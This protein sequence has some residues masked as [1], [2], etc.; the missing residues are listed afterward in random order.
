MTG[1]EIPKYG[2]FIIESMN[3]D[4]ELN[5]DLDGYALKSMLDIC[6]IPNQYFYIRTKKELIKIIEVFRDSDF[7]FLHLACHANEEKIATTYDHIS[8][9]ELDQILGQYLYHRRL[10]ISAC[11]AA[12]L[13]LAQ[14]F[15][16][17][18]H[19]YSVIGSPDE[20][21]C[22]KAA[23]FWS[24]YYHLMYEINQINM[25]QRQL[26]PILESLTKTFK[27]KLNYFAIINNQ[28]SRSIDHL[29]EINYDSGIKIDDNY[30]K[31]DY[32]NIYR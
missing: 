29:R 32:R 23:I 6:H 13:E 12:R 10:F 21:F 18:Y 27:I 5:G 1:K 28:N 20:I 3:L 22:D 7:G 31:T 11:K 14:H 26:M 9:D 24:S 15:I 16:P 17:K 2:V 30:R 8:F 19:C 4:D 25:P